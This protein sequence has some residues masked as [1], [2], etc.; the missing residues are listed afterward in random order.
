MPSLLDGALETPDLHGGERGPAAEARGSHGPRGRKHPLCASTEGGVLRAVTCHKRGPYTRKGGVAQLHPIVSQD[1][2]GHCSSPDRSLIPQSAPSC[3]AAPL[4]PALRGVPVQDPPPRAAAGRRFR[5]Q[6]RPPP[7]PAG[8]C[9]YLPTSQPQRRRVAMR[10]TL[11][12]GSAP[13]LSPKGTSRVGYHNSH[14]P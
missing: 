8:V 10:R 6:P 5:G 1:L 9:P 3:R 12:S 7:R 11:W 14:P 13:R 4:Q 2:H